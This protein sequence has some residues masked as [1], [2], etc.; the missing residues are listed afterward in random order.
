MKYCLVFNIPKVSYIDLN[1]YTKAILE[2]LM[3]NKIGKIKIAG[4]ISNKRILSNSY[5]K[6]PTCI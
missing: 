6:V 5:K 2:D 4:C 3:S 1:Y